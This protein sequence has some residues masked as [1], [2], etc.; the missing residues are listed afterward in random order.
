MNINKSRAFQFNSI[1]EI[2]FIGMILYILL[3]T[4]GFYY[5]III[6]YKI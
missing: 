2:I 3:N 5:Y 1:G 6:L 4:N